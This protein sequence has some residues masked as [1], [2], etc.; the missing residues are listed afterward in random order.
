[1]YLLTQ[2]LLVFGLHV[3]GALRRSGTR[4]GRL[5]VIGSQLIETVLACLAASLLSRPFGSLVMQGC[6]VDGIDDWYPWLHNPATPC[7]AM[8]CA[9]EAVYP[10]LTWVLTVDAV[11]AVL[12]VALRLPI[13][14]IKAVSASGVDSVFFSLYLLPVHAV[15]TVVLGGIGYY[16]YPYLLIL[17]G[18][19]LITVW[20]C[21]ATRQTLGRMLR[22]PG[23]GP[24]LAFGYGTAAMGIA[25]SI[26]YFADDD[27]A[28]TTT[29]LWTASVFGPLILVVI[30]LATE[31]I[32]CPDQIVAGLRGIG[33][34][35][36]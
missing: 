13:T 23:L 36:R 14:R 22:D 25:A 1:M 8:D 16:M 6:G 32:T 20:M 29:A 30:Y 7:T 28:T 33:R 4:R 27:A 12:S 31:R 3:W 19:L 2:V 34:A 35:A 21:S 26:S 9:N 10:L 11:S 17:T 15:L 24:I 18:T 5:L